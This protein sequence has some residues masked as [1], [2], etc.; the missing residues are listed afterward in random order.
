M[1]YNSTFY[2]HASLQ[3]GKVMQI[4]LPKLKL[5]K[6]LFLHSIKIPLVFFYIGLFFFALPILQNIYHFKKMETILNVNNELANIFFIVALITFLYNMFATC[7][8]F[9]E[10]KF[11]RINKSGALIVR[12]VRKSS[13]II[14]ILLAIGLVVYFSVH[15]QKIYLYFDE[16][17]KLAVIITIGFI[18]IEILYT[19]EDIITT[20]MKDTNLEDRYQ[21]YSLYTKVRIL[22]NVGVFAI[23]V[24]T[25]ATILMSFSSV[26]NIGISLLA[27][28]GVITA[29]IGFSGQ[30]TLASIFSGIQLAITQPIKIGDTVSIDGEWGIVE[31]ISFTFVTIRMLDRRKLIIPIDYF[32]TNKFENWTR[33]GNSLTT[34]IYFKVD[35]GM[36]IEPIRIELDK[37]LKESTY[38]DGLMHKIFINK[39]DSS[40]V[41]I[42]AQISSKDPEHLP[43]FCSEVREK[44]LQFLRKQYADHLPK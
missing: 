36:P 30:K 44:I 18:L 27:S 43:E 9:Y 19:I 23:S 35:Y 22:R 8:T 24:V 37:I 28:A 1:D 16:I 5:P 32:I 38:W 13:R 3:I 2:L 40:G 41:E 21:I 25:I 6:H 17:F 26:R 4:K 10:Q 39:L 11:A 42:R 7:C 34:S 15:F 29:F 12:R 14:F 20:K 31:E 33:V